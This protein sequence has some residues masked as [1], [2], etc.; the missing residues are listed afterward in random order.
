MFL[1]LWLIL[2]YWQFWEQSETLLKSFL[3]LFVRLLTSFSGED[4]RRR[5]LLLLRKPSICCLK[6][7]ILRYQRDL[8]WNVFFS[9]FHSAVIHLYFLTPPRHPLLHFPALSQYMAART[10]GTGHVNSASS[11][12]LCFRLIILAVLSS[13]SPSEGEEN[14]SMSAR[15]KWW[16]LMLSPLNICLVLAERMQF[17]HSLVTI[18]GLPKSVP[19]PGLW[20]R[21]EGVRVGFWWGN[22]AKG[23]WVSLDMVRG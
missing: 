20:G 11:L 3:K 21:E 15:V 12:V 4:L 8:I 16:L 2:V 14:R 19:E 13:F 22:G 23:G 17:P 6:K 7:K 5:R 18:K 10:S 1:D 9:K